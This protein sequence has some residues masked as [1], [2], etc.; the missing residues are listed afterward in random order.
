MNWDQLKTILWLRS[1]LTRNQWAKGGGIGGI[2]AAIVAIAGV[3][4]AISSV[5]A[6]VSARILLPPDTSLNVLMVIWL[7]ITAGFLFIW[8]IGLISELQRSESIDLQRLMHLPVALGQIFVINYAASHLTM[9]V[10]VFV[11]A[12]VGLSVGFAISRGPAWLL[13]IPLALGMI[14]MITAWTY[15]LRGWLAT[16]MSNP[17]RRRAVIMGV[18]AAFIVIAQA[19]NIYFNVIRREDKSTRAQ[20]RDRFGRD[21]PLLLTDTD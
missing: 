7:G 12:M 10:A 13:M 3:V 15:C 8:L 6:D 11:P 5:I 21:P 20:R 18:T 1:R 16:L 17:R 2:I 14:F 19:P 9:S 4:M